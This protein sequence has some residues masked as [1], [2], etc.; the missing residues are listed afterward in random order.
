MEELRKGGNLKVRYLKCSHMVTQRS[1]DST[2]QEWNEFY[3][4]DN[5]NFDTRFPYALI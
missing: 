4:S 3:F 1:A 5:T 2:G